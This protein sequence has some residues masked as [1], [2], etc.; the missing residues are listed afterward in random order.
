MDNYE[1]TEH[2]MAAN[3]L[4]DMYKDA[5]GFRPSCYHYDSMSIEEM[6]SE[7][8]ELE[9][10][11]IY[12]VQEERKIKARKIETFENLI[13]ELRENQNID[14]AT[15]IRWL[16]DAEDCQQAKHDDDYFCFLYGLPGG[17]LKRKRYE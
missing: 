14:R 4:S 5:H 11:I 1:P 3:T 15:A 17:Y 16:R 12:Q 10:I 6:H 8:S 7:M 9:K 13:T 2:E